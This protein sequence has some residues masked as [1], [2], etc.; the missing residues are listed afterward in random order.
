MDPS[1]ENF[2]DACQKADIQKIKALMAEG[3]NIDARDTL[4]KS[5]PMHYA[6]YSEDLE[7]IKYMIDAG[8]PVNIK[9][10]RDETPLHWA[11][12]AGKMMIVWTLLN[13]GAKINVKDSLS[14]TP[15]DKAIT[16]RHYDAA[17]LLVNTIK[18]RKPSVNTDDY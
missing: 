7:T 12:L 10:D 2:L 5:S 1:D 9:N 14:Q 3:A 11:A 8:A 16:Y 13:A 15:L 6:V 18:K 4:H 17:I